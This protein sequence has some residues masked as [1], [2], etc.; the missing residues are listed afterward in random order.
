MV[1]RATH[2][3]RELS[4]DQRFVEAL[5]EVLGLMPLYERE[6]LANRSEIER[7]A[8]REAVMPAAPRRLPY[9]DFAWRRMTYVKVNPSSPRPPR[10]AG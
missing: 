1:T 9:G 7:F 3:W 10:R 5:R 8:P 2:V 6:R 4:L